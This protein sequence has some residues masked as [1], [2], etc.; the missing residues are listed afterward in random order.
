MALT[1]SQ[2]AFL[3]ARLEAAGGSFADIE[4][5]SFGPSTHQGPMIVSSDPTRDNMSSKKVEVKDLAQYKAVGG[6]PDSHFDKSAGADRHITYLDPPKV[7]YA[8]LKAKAKADSCALESLLG[9]DELDS[10]GTQMRAYVLGDSRKVPK[11][12]E[13][14]INAVKFPMT[15]V[16]AGGED[17]TIT[18]Q[19][20]LILE[21]DAPITLHYGTMTIEKGGYIEANVPVTLNVTHMIIE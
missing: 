6:P 9:S 7:D 15:A 14:M 11:E 10:L 20:P 2:K 3:S 19:N 13:E 16:M 1:D 18:A 4:A 17:I 21:G 8:G 12:H 5:K